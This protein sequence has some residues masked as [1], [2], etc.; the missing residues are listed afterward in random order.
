MTAITG[1]VGGERVVVCGGSLVSERH[2]LTAAHCLTNY[3]TDDLEVRLGE[4]NLRKDG[5]LMRNEWAMFIT[6]LKLILL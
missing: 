3:D 6:F 4:T 1:S 2:V 5:S